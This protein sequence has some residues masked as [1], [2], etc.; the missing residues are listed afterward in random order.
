MIVITAIYNGISFWG[1]ALFNSAPDILIIAPII[2]NCR[3]VM[4]E[5]SSSSHLERTNEKVT[6]VFF[7]QED[8]LILLYTI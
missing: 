7:T 6:M 3:A 2:H 5:M 4:N 8:N 1:F